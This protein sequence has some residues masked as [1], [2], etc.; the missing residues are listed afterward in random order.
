MSAKRVSPGC[1]RDC[2]V[3]SLGHWHSF[4]I[5]HG[6]TGWHFHASCKIHLWANVRVCFPLACFKKL[7][8]SLPS[9]LAAVS[10]LL[11][12]GIW[13]NCYFGSCLTYGIIVLKHF[14]V[15]LV[16]SEYFTPVASH[17][18][19]EHTIYI[20]FR[21]RSRS[22][23]EVAVWHGNVSHSWINQQITLSSF[24]SLN[25]YAPKASWLLT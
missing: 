10:H 1:L 11:C 15:C 9:I 21:K 25:T 8:F 5:N 23:E 6:K 16:L 24:R 14:T 13:S 4:R 2:P 18:G 17:R 22:P 19:L 20:F 3:W 7:G 12:K